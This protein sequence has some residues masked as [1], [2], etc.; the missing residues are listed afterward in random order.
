MRPFFPTTTNQLQS[1]SHIWN[2]YTPDLLSTMAGCV[3]QRLLTFGPRVGSCHPSTLLTWPVLCE[4]AASVYYYGKIMLSSL[5]FP[6]LN[7]IIIPFVLG[8]FSLSLYKCVFF[9]TVIWWDYMLLVWR[10]LTCTQSLRKL[11]G[12]YSKTWILERTMVSQL[13]S[14][15]IIV[16]TIVS[17]L[18]YH[19][20]MMSIDDVARA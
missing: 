14:I 1:T 15:L 18:L 2:S 20:L 10:K 16:V 17:C 9:F 7:I 11:P 8:A 6:S 3:Y 12:R 5:S 13:V 19:V 4:N